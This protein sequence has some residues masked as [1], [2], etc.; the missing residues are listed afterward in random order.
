[1]NQ[2]SI[3]ALVVDLGGVAARFRPQRR[4]HALASATRIEE[5]VVHERLF[6][7]GFDHRCE[8]GEL[9]AAETMSA[10]LAALDGTITVDAVIE[11]WSLAFAPDDDVLERVRTTRGR[12]V[13][14]TNNGPLLDACLAGPLNWLADEFDDVICSWHLR[15]T[16]PG[17]VAFERAAIRLGVPA[18]QLLLL[19]DSRANVQAAQQVGWKA[20]V[21]ADA[22]D[23][24]HALEQYA[25]R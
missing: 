5:H 3:E 6:G 13:L 1:M 8:L 18:G 21:V 10:V 7:S 11:A 17:A 14:F 22:G 9:T 15:A 2:S 19:D 23:V 20:A 12:R 16:K 4:L 25:L 24:G